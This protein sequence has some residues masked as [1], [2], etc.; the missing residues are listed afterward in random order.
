MLLL[1]SA[2][3]AVLSITAFSAV[4]GVENRFFDGPS[5][6]PAA[7]QTVDRAVLE[8]QARGRICRTEPVLT[9]HVVFQYAVADSVDV[10]A[11]AEA[12]A[13]MRAGAGSIQRYC[14]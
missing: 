14:F 12:V 3:I 5:Q 2:V 1:V 4:H 6:A 8:Q 10:L 11:L 7:S 13:A 9:D